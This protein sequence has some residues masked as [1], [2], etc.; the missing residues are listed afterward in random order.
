MPFR[1]T[2][3]VDDEFSRSYQAI[4]FVVARLKTSTK[5]KA[6]EAAKMLSTCSRSNKELN[7]LAES[8]DTMMVTAASLQEELNRII[9]L[10]NR[11]AV[12]NNKSK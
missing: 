1:Q 8:V 11:I 5:S 10:D 2:T 4:Y 7:S 3:K 9:W 12:L 6:A